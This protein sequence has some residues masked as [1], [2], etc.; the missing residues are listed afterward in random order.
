[1][2]KMGC[3]ER[4]SELNCRRDPNARFQGEIRAAARGLHTE[5]PQQHTPVKAANQ[6]RKLTEFRAGV[7]RW[8]KSGH[9]GTYNSAQVD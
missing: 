2:V 1:L 7:G 8:L 9:A 5:E 3:I 6:Q 4:L